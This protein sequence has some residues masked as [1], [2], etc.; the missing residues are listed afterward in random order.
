MKAEAYSMTMG[1]IIS[2]RFRF[3][4]IFYFFGIVQLIADLEAF[5]VSVQ[6]YLCYLCLRDFFPFSSFLFSHVQTT[7]SQDQNKGTPKES[8]SYLLLFLSLSCIDT[9]RQKEGN[10]HFLPFSNVV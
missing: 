2:F 3:S 8:H 9:N 1:F 7:V 10:V 5:V 6:C 4:E